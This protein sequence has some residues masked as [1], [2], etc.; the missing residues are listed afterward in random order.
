MPQQSMTMEAPSGMS[1]TAS[2]KLANTLFSILLTRP[3]SA[4]IPRRRESIH[5]LS[6]LPVGAFRAAALTHDYATNLI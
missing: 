5:P 2:S 3:H 6:R 1:A 4:V